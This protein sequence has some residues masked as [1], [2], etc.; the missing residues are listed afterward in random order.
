[1]KDQRRRFSRLLPVV[2][3][4]LAGSSAWALDPSKPPGQNFDLSHWKLTL[5]VDSSGGTN[6]DA[7]DISAAQLVAGYTNA[8][9]FYTGPDGA[10]TFWCPVTGATTS[11]SSYPR[12]E[13]R[14]EIIP[15]NDNTNWTGYGT[16][17]LDGQCKVLQ[18]PSSGKTIIGQIHSFLGNAYPLIK[19]QYNSGTVEALVKESS[20]SDTDTDFSFANGNVGLSNSITY[21]IKVVDGLLTLSVNGSTQSVNFFVTDPNWETNTFYFKAGDY[22]QDNVGT[23]NEG[24][25]VSFYAV[26]VSHSVTGAPSITTQP[27]NQTVTAGQTA[28]FSVVATGTVPLSY[29]WFFN[30]NTTLAQATNATLT[31]TNV[32]PTNAGVYSVTVT[33]SAGSV[34]SLLATLTLNAPPSITNQPANLTVATGQN[35]AFTVGAAGTAPLRY[36]WRFNATNNLSSATN[37]SLTITNAQSTNAGDYTV[38]VTNAYGAVT[39][40]IATLTVSNQPPTITTQPVDQVVFVT[41]TASFFVAATGGRSVSLSMAFQHHQRPLG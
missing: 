1:M 7:V 40:A 16:H 2:L 19:L 11:G 15:G 6:G 33:N 10:M 36:R 20:S 31:L 29:Q 24:G 38:V 13:L 5:P 28:S 23:T 25:L 14:E 18:V 32:Q 3:A 8:L 21:E 37:A 27:T 26:S 34:T 35:A 41:Q 17:I 4:W 30:T 12:S 39:S 22:C 9:Y